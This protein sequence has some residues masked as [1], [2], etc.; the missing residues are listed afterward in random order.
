[1]RKLSEFICTVFYFGLSPKAPGTVGSIASLGLIF[2]VV[3]V[4][5]ILWCVFAFVVATVLGFVFVPVYLAGSLKDKQEIVIDEASGL[6]FSILLTVCFLR[7]YKIE[8]DWFIVFILCFIFFRIFDITK[9]L[10]VKYFDNIKGTF[11][12]M[13]DDISAGFLSAIVVCG[14]MYTVN[15]VLS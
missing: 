7:Y 10:F 14:V 8:A 15:I 2:P 11:G 1:M 6:Y 12:I 3:W 5:S 4:P 13:M 9:P